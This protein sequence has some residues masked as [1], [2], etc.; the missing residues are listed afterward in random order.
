MTRTPLGQRMAAHRAF[1]K[2]PPE[3]QFYNAYG[4]S[5]RSPFIDFAFR[6]ARRVERRRYT[7]LSA[8]FRRAGSPLRITK[9]HARP[10]IPLRSCIDGHVYKIYSRNLDV[11]VFNAE[12][13][14]FTGIRN[15]FGWNYLFSEFH[16][17]QG[18]P[19]GTVSP[20]EDLGPLPA[21]I[22]DNLQ[23]QN[24]P[25]FEYLD[26]TFYGGRHGR[27]NA[28]QA[29]AAARERAAEEA[30]EA[31]KAAEGKTPPC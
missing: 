7:V 15:K 4:R 1:L 2:N 13:E 17:D 26:N 27:E 31:A 6:C 9:E 25:L 14:A 12:H 29:L 28:E 19:Y 21:G 24:Q 8:A 22:T 30:E 5:G 20:L 3:G 10:H 23:L 11:G 18:P 16:Y